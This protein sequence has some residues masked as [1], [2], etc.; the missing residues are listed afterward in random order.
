[1]R[2]K[3]ILTYVI[4]R[5]IQYWTLLLC[6]I[7]ALCTPENNSRNFKLT[8]L[9]EAEEKQ[10][11]MINYKKKTVWNQILIST[12]DLPKRFDIICKKPMR[13]PLSASFIEIHLG[14]ENF[15]VK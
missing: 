8:E 15:S 6:K 2:S 7:H 1:M 12:T 3:S 10:V 5:K 11:P 4:A 9:I 14:Y 13:A